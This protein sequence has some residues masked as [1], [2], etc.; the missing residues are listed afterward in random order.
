MRYIVT[1]TIIPLKG[2]QKYGLDILNQSGSNG[3]FVVKYGINDFWM[4][5]SMIKRLS[6]E[7]NLKENMNQAIKDTWWKLL[8]TAVVLF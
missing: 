5:E 1:V 3:A 4:K 2:C 6:E 7:A 8:L